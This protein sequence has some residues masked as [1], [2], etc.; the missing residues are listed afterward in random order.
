M[1]NLNPASSKKDP[2]TRFGWKKYN[3]YFDESTIKV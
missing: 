2:K 1:P 3:K